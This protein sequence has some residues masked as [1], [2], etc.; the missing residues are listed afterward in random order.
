MNDSCILNAEFFL[1]ALTVLY[2]GNFLYLLEPRTLEP[3]G[4]WLIYP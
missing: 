3:L 2:R 4:P 1:H